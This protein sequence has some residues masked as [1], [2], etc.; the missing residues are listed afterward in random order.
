M[1]STSERKALIDTWFLTR[2]TTEAGYI[3]YLSSNSLRGW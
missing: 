2:S 1:C 3:A